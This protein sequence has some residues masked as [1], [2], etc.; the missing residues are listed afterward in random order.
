MEQE[1][2][3]SLCHKYRLAQKAVLILYSLGD[4][5][6]AHTNHPYV[7]IQNPT[8]NTLYDICPQL[9]RWSYSV[10]AVG[11]LIFAKSAIQKE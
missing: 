10:H 6:V 1:Y 4:S 8:F 9:Q 7:E 11:L 2:A 5:T 3:H